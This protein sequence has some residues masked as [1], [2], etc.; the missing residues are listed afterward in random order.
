MESS[1]ASL[2]K[3]CAVVNVL[4]FEDCTSSK[5]NDYFY[6]RELCV[7]GYNGSVETEY[8]PSAARIEELEYQLERNLAPARH[9][10]RQTEE[11]HGMPYFSAQPHLCKNTK[12]LF[13]N[14][15]H[16]YILFSTKGKPYMATSDPHT[17]GT[18]LDKLNIP[19]VNL[20][21]GNY[22]YSP[23]STSELFFKEQE[24]RACKRHFYT[25][26][27]GF[28][29]SYV[30]AV[31]DAHRCWHHILDCNCLEPTGTTHIQPG[32]IRRITAE[33][34]LYRMHEYNPF[35]VDLCGSGLENHRVTMKDA[36]SGET[37]RLATEFISLTI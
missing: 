22:S 30:C 15:Y 18:I 16:A 36:A 31:R 20:S 33:H 24:Q 6:A 19:W 28:R 27:T 34:P 5:T 26:A 13:R 7:V 8:E 37:D 2:L 10:Q 4:G 21:V 12:H 3:V 11:F 25:P 23:N 9:F 29:P 14:L 35:S 17:A 1:R 32:E